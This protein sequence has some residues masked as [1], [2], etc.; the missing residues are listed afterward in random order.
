[1]V[2]FEMDLAVL[3]KDH[4]VTVAVCD[5]TLTG[6]RYTNSTDATTPCIITLLQQ[7]ATPIRA[8]SCLPAID[9]DGRRVPAP[10]GVSMG[11]EP[12]GSLG[13]P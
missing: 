7:Q 1:M 6:I 12:P 4:A 2:P 5:D 11:A 9:E 3:S 13:V 8:L 10:G